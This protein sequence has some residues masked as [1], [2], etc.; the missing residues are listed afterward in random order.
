MAKI[1]QLLEDAYDDV[2][3][4]VVAGIKSHPQ[5]EQLVGALAEKG[6]AALAALISSAA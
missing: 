3:A 5:Y 1:E 2:K 4:D 6:F